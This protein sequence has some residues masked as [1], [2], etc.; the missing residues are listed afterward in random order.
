[1]APTTFNLRLILRKATTFVWTPEC[2]AEF[3]QIK[4]I[5]CDERYIWP[6]G[7]ELDTDLLVDTSKVAGAGYILI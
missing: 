1:M 6:F 5:L 3:E 7:P 2:E 4:I